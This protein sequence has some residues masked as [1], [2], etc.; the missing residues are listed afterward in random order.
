MLSEV[1]GG[2]PTDP[3]KY[4]T[5]DNEGLETAISASLNHHGLLSVEGS[6]PLFELRVALAALIPSGPGFTTSVTAFIRYKLSEIS[7]DTPIYDDV[8]EE[9]STLS[10]GDVFLGI[11]RLQR[12]NENAVH[13]TILT[14]LFEICALEF[15]T[16]K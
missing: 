13:A 3:L 5:V 8:I 11:E 12:A 9:T 16:G 14:F 2:E 6:D 7:T 1:I 10:S 4:S 15:D